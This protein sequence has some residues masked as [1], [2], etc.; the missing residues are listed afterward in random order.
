MTTL[1]RRPKSL[2]EYDD[3]AAA[4][5]KIETRPTNFIKSLDLTH[6]V[7]HSICNSK[8]KDEE[9]L[10]QHLTEY[11][12]VDLISFTDQLAY[13]ESC[14]DEIIVDTASVLDLLGSLSGSFKS[15]E[16]ET[17]TFQ[18]QCEELLSDQKRLID[19]VDGIGKDLQYYSYL[20][21][22]TKRLNAP[23]SGRLVNSDDFLES[24]LNLNAC[25]DFMS[26]HPDYRDS[27]IYQSRYISL[28]ERALNL[29]QNH[30]SYCFKEVTDEVIQ[31]LRSKDHTETA[32]YVLL[33][34]KYESIKYKLGSQIEGLL[35][36][37][38]FTFGTLGQE[39]NLP[40]YALRYHELWSQIVDIYLKNRE[41]VNDVVSKNLKKF[42]V[43]EDPENDFETFARH[44][45]QYV[46]DICNSEQTLMM[47][48]FKDGPLMANYGTLNGW[49]KNNNYSGRLEENTLLY[50]KTLHSYLTTYMSG[51]DLQAICG[52]VN[53]LEIMYLTSTDGEL[54]VE[55]SKTDRAAIAQHYLGNYLWKFMDEMFL[56]S[57]IDI[58]HYIPSQEDLT[59]S[60]ITCDSTLEILG[61]EK[62]N[63]IEI[64]EGGLTSYAYPTVKVAAKLLMQYNDGFAER[65]RTS[66]I[67]YEI[68][69]QTT[70]SLQKAA[71]LIKRNSN[72]MDAQIFLIKNLLLL[73]NLFM[74][75]EI[76][77]LVRQSAEF[78]FSPIW[79]TISD[80]QAQRQLFNP[81]AYITPLV[82]GRL[83]PAVI[84]RVLDARK[85][86][87][88]IL[89]QQITAFTKTWQSQLAV[90]DKEKREI[91]EVDL[92]K[93][94]QQNFDEKTRAALW[95]IIGTD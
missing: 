8:E 88:N 75:H 31:E 28:L 38:E 2:C 13:T 80:L 55:I 37:P 11:K 58:E 6:P 22:L 26:Q 18:G 4:H 46:L 44:A 84:D 1:V 95:K 17:S 69:H 82:R 25:I 53:W 54:D 94:L 9:F 45:V 34:G 60:V 90:G 27:S 47:K 14:L 35:K 68:V 86:V 12:F 66:E 16:S 41:P 33:Y 23:G 30:I 91:I 73:E 52:L 43:V 70:K 63:N 39:H 78:D 15:V 64:S 29:V 40:P 49:N 7:D 3:V 93:V 19:L 76:P 92:D 67:L 62:E 57:A 21:P 81:L 59:I 42:T 85:E 74:T 61:H 83:L 10:S 5:S 71:T 24:L 65:P 51:D 56:K 36:Y 32:E 89:V 77:D 87:E 79:S 72:M 50:L 48:F 20:E